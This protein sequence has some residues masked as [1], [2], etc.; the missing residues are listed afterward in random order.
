MPV[1]SL[2]RDPRS[3]VLVLGWLLAILL[4]G[5][6]AAVPVT[7]PVE[8]HT[9][10]APGVDPGVR[11]DPLPPADGASQ[12][13]VVEGFLHA[14]GTYQPDYAVAR[15]YLTEE[16]SQA[17]HPESGVQIYDSSMLPT[18]TEQSVVLSARVTGEVDAAGTYG[19]VAADSP[20]L[21]QDFGMV[22]NSAGQWR[23]S[24]PPKG[25]LVS[26]YVFTTGFTS[27]SLFFSDPDRTV[28]VPEPRVFADGES[29]PE[30]AAAALLEGP[31]RWLRPA[32]ASP[33]TDQIA[34][35]GL[36][37]SPNGIAEVEL[38]GAAELEA[39]QRRI[40][41]AQLTYTLTGF[42]QIHAIQVNADGQA[43]RDDS[44]STVVTPGSFSRLAAAGMGAQPGLYLVQKKSVFRLEDP[45]NWDDQTQVELRF[46]QP[47]QI[48]VKANE[49][50][51]AAVTASAT[52]LQVTQL[53]ADRATSLRSGSGL[54]RP[55]YAR[56]GELWSPAAGKPQELQIFRDG[57]R[58]SARL[59]RNGAGAIPQRKV[60]AL[61]L[62]PDGVRAAL[63][64]ADGERTEIGL[65]RIQRSAEGVTLSGW[66]PIRFPVITG[67]AGPVRDLG[68]ISG[69]ELVLLQA[70]EK[71]TGVLR[72]A[73]DGS[74]STDIGPSEPTTLTQLAV[75]PG[76][77]I[78]ARTA[79]GTLLRRDGDFNWNLAVTDITSVAYSA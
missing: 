58:V 24:K 32:V 21:R 53:G 79:S 72:V 6:C 22:E 40:L 16:A 9:P 54:L 77:T 47:E 68:W 15:Q 52:Q 37:V 19:S 20:P 31:S 3:L 28:L 26:E 59:S 61:A 41:L 1:A 69:T 12:L 11:V 4:V 50:E 14:M 39:G 44:G 43:W 48:A 64:L 62:A 73:Q 76:R 30:V 42:S 51:F 7:G 66:Q 56:N 17:W 63:A 29:T 60:L 67:N 36:T 75:S 70:D 55:G 65:V 2:P 34:L 46:T 35:L 10:A 13:L 33:D 18:Q 27:V 71:G 23:I 57:K 49:A 5:G 8:H 74:L 25:L 45:T 38:E 78:L